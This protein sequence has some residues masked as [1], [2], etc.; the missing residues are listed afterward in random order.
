MM[1][2][3]RGLS[4]NTTGSST[5][6]LLS[7]LTRRGDEI[8][9]APKGQLGL[10]TVHQPPSQNSVIADLIFV[11]G[12]NG[13]SR[14][15]WTKAHTS[16]L[17]WP[18]EWLPK[19]LAF[20]DVRIHTF[21]YP[22]GLSRKSVLNVH[23]FAR[24]LL[25]A[26]NDSPT[27]NQGQTQGQKPP[28][29]FIAHS[30]GG[31]VVKKAYILGHQEAEFLPIVDRV[32]SIFFL[33]TPHQGAA[34]AQTLSKLALLA[35][36]RP[37]VDDLLPQSEMLQSINEEFPRISSKL[38]LIS[39]YETRPMSIGVSRS[40][41]VEKQ[42][43]VMNLPN[44][45]R[46]LLDA[47]HRHVAKFSSPEDSTYLAIRNALATVVNSQR[48]SSQSQKSALAL[49]DQTALN[50]FLG[51]SDAPED[52]VM[53]Y[54]SY[55]Q[56]GSCEWF[57]TRD[58]YRS[59]RDV[60]DARFLWLRGRPGAGKSVLASQVINDLRTRG[61][62]CCFFFFQMG[63]SSKCSTYDLLKSFAW[64][65][66][67]LHPAVSAKMGDLVT[68]AKGES[69]DGSDVNLLW[70][71]V[72]LSG[73]LKI[74]LNRPQFWVIDAMDECKGSADLMGFL[75]RAQEQWPISVLVT[76]RN[77]VEAHLGKATHHIDIRSECISDEDSKHDISLFLKMHIGLLPFPTSSKW[78]TPW[79]MATHIIQKSGGC[80]LW[81]S[82]ICS[83]LREAYTERE[84]EQILESIPADMDS[85]YAKILD[86]MANARFGKDLAK[87]LLT[88]STYCFRPLSTAE[89][90]EP[91]E[92][93]I[94]DKIDDIERSISKCCGN[95]IYVDAQSRVQLIHLTA[96][97]FLTKPDTKSEFAVS[98]AE[99]HR[100]LAMVC[101]KH[102]IKT[103]STPTRPRRLGS[104]QEVRSV[105][106]SWP[107]SH[108][109]NYASNFLFRHLS[110][111]QSND[112]EILLTLAK[113]LGGV[114]V[115]RWIEFIARNGDL[116][117]IYLAGKTINDLLRRRA[118]HS[119]PMGFA[120]KHMTFVEKWGDD[121]IHLITKF[122]GLLKSV[123]QSIH[124]L[125]PPFCPSGSAIRQ[126]F[127]SPYR[128]ISVH[129]IS[130]Q[131]WDDCL[132]TIIYPK[133]TRPNVVAA[134]S[135][136]FAIGMMNSQIRVYDESIFQEMHVLQHREPVWRLAFSTTGEYLASAGAK[137]VRIWSPR[138][139]QELMSFAIPSLC[140]AISFG[141]EDN[142]LRVATRQEDH[143]IEWDME[144]KDFF[145]EEASNWTSDLEEAYQ[146]RTPTMIAF[147]PA[148]LLSVI[149]RGE[150]LVLWDF[151]E[152]RI[153]DIYEQDVGSK[154]HGSLRVSGG[155]STVR[156]VTFSDAPDSNLLAT[157]YTEGDLVVYDILEGRPIANASAVNTLL[158]ASSHD[159]RTLAG[160]DSKGNLTLFD[161]ETLRCLYRVRFDTAIIPKGL[162]FTAD[163]R[164]FVEV[165]GDQCRVWEPT[166][167][168]R[169]ET[170]EEDVSDTVS[171]STGPQEISYQMNEAVKIAAVCCC[172]TLDA[173]FFAKDDGSVY[174][175]EIGGDPESHLLF[176]QTA[177]CPVPFFSWDEEAM[178]LACGDLSGRVTV[179]RISRRNGLRRTIIWGVE[180]PLIDL[181]LSGEGPIRQLLV[182]GRHGRLLVASERFD[183]L[184][185][186][187]EGEE[188]RWIAQAE[189][190]GLPVWASHPSN[191]DLLLRATPLG[192]ETYEWLTQ[193]LLCTTGVSFGGDL[194]RLLSLQ[195]Q[196]FVA[197]IC[198]SKSLHDETTTLSV[199]VW[200]CDRIGPGHSSAVPEREVVSPMPRIVHV[201]GAFSNRLVV[202]MSD[203]WIAS[204]DMEAG[205]EDTL[206]RHFLVPPDW[207]SVANRFI[208]GIGRSA[209]VLIAKETDL[210]IIRRGLE[211]LENG[212]TFNPRR[213]SSQH[214]ASLTIRQG[215]SR[216]SSPGSMR[217]Y[218]PS[219]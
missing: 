11:H 193:K 103:Q 49:A 203:Y 200:D 92:I 149:Y 95:L 80:F 192:F 186:L 87:A 51:I 101:L 16:S 129:G 52:D 27:I 44:E 59:W 21:G 15:T 120:Q 114:S 183:T 157:T 116:H 216:G 141:E 104:D 53:T 102:L 143:L 215:R 78:A 167:L 29:I 4:R 98:K 5:R 41:I 155:S 169:Q 154:R 85:L 158:I 127:F 14:S 194:H 188:R 90:K 117:T 156:A 60:A 88:W 89:I 67:M 38:Q 26:I 190:N 22:S 162:A 105:Q 33:A 100:R 152:E 148:N 160:C 197:S 171:I 191:P 177:G 209:E 39:F 168:L 123:P 46:T 106:G 202:S 31:L 91:I 198:G 187:P 173:A 172:R 61:M 161:F 208:M 35:G 112:E 45:R 144:A 99:G 47:D 218:P 69:I 50:R 56:P 146:F 43:G 76:S 130:S 138:R 118:Q 159:G 40:L 126:Q 125:I 185:P 34:L 6:S 176:V 145:R 219:R 205:R 24:S 54:D 97:E 81:V 133:G 13:G 210:A 82:L 131:G 107:T 189:G 207:I 17:F 217:S 37:F 134:G 1:A 164:R 108:F 206:V 124:H 70:R 136:Y 204:I 79:D 135:G 165:R 111:V 72:F 86:D 55:R 96:R 179:R 48:E 140:L 71:K 58:D 184:W 10:S 109:T 175:Y 28:L 199:Q 182:S 147:G 63:D 84:I 214:G 139:G 119:P 170:Q 19:D 77:P 25:A 163:N 57:L 121:L 137:R 18:Q 62:D 20:Q 8:T 115:L 42:C 196:R 153:H 36:A 65:M 94:N 68:E 142:V 174:A 166:V 3:S 213:G 180:E 32:C 211:S 181:H 64:Q 74:R 7:S 178:I 73:I 201:L 83:E 212:G 9:G 132:T 110:Q 23:D 151:I 128:G 75:A 12:L 66:S 113:F 30:M 150:D 2:P 122:S 195:H 93:D